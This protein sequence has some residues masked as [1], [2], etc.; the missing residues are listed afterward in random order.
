MRSG[1]DPPA[2]A[3]KAWRGVLLRASL[4]FCARA[5]HGDGQRNITVPLIARQTADARFRGSDPPAPQPDATLVRLAPV[6][7]LHGS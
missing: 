3:R 6:P 4:V 7:V 5:S 1:Y 2:E